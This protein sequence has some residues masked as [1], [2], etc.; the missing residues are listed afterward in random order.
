MWFNRLFF[1]CLL[2]SSSALG[3]S[4]HF[5]NTST[6]LV[7]TTDQSPAHWYIEIFSDVPVDT[8]LRWITHFTTIPTAWNIT[9]DDGDTNYPTIQDLDSNDFVLLTNQ[10]F[11][12][13]LIIGAM[14]ND[15]PGNGSVC[16]DVFDPNNRAQL[17]TICYHFVISQG[18]A[19]LTSVLPNDQFN[20]TH[21]EIT[22][23]GE[24]LVEYNVFDSSGK[25]IKKQLENTLNI[26]DLPKNQT[27]FIEVKFEGN[28][29][30]IKIIN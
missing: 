27:I 14:L 9:F 24:A 16:F 5:N 22:Y 25:Q 18:T 28:R 7:K 3:Q 20:V 10:A 4:F 2:W 17:T 29:Y 19:G 12:Q 6:T 8:T 11:P 13:K 30:I 23:L 26:I 21:Q 1:C 15:T